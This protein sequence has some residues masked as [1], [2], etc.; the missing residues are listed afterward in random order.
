MKSLVQ[1]SLGLSKNFPSLCHSLKLGSV[2]TLSLQITHTSLQYDVSGFKTVLSGMLDFVDL[3]LGNALA[4]TSNFISSA[5]FD[6]LKRINLP[7]LSQLLVIAP[8][9]TIITFLS[10]VNILVHTQIRLQS[11]DLGECPLCDNYSQFCSALAQHYSIDQVSSL[12]IIH[13]AAIKPDS[14]F[15]DPMLFIFSTSPECDCPSTL[16]IVSL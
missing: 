4:S 16:P 10:S 14:S 1:N 9:S 12:S 3:F 2:T 6:T 11:P 8:L 13:S 5:E 15:Y 7:C